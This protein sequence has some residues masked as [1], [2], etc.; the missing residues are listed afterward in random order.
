MTIR[1]KKPL[2]IRIL[3]ISIAAITL[4][5]ISFCIWFV[6][7]M[8]S[9][10]NDSARYPFLITEGETSQTIAQN[11]KDQNF[12]K[13]D[14]VFLAVL[15]LAGKSL[16]PGIHYLSPSFDVM[17]IVHSLQNAEKDTITVRIQSGKT[18]NEL[19]QDFLAL[20][21]VDD[22]ITQAFNA[23]YASPLFVDKPQAASL[24]GY[25]FPDTYYLAITDGL[26]VLFEKA[27]TH[28]YDQ[29][30]SDGSLNEIQ[31][32]GRT[33]YEILTL[34]S[35]TQKEV[36]VAEDQKMVA[37]VFENRLQTGMNLGSD[38]TFKYAY[39]QG[40]CS[41]N[42]PFCDS[43]YNTRIYG[44]LPPGPIA[45]MEYS[46]IQAV[47]HPSQH[48]YYFFVAGDDGI[49]RYSV[50]EEEHLWKTAQYCTV[51]CQ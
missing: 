45:N 21:F 27:F 12:I 18:L 35:I 17:R 4:A 32:Q 49:T 46:A 43:T 5:C 6:V 48:N 47:I 36:S 14:F 10:G 51:L 23:Q 15:K 34:A 13:N 3:W 2:L 39:A 40:F 26:T 24:E 25:I 22:E 20:G 33:I 44:G 8:Q 28:L 1:L 7:N 42:S 11:L 37:G 31:N 38:P 19:R 41:Q 9:P 50:T 30:S 16:I 29:L